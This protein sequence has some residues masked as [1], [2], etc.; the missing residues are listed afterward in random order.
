M[1]L[2]PMLLV[3]TYLHARSAE[4]EKSGIRILLL[5]PT[6]MQ[7]LPE[8]SSMVASDTAASVMRGPAP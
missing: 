4:G 5:W 6:L 1:W 3:E 2:Y 8:A 7:R